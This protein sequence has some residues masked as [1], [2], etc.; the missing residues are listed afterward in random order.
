MNKPIMLL[1]GL[2]SV[3]AQADTFSNISPFVGAKGGWQFADDNSYQ[4]TNPSNYLL[5]FYGGL[6]FTP[7][8]SW[9]IG[10][11]Y[12]GKLKADASKVSIKTALIES[13]LRYD[14]YF[15]DD[16]SVY[17]RLGVVYWD[18]N[19]TQNL[20]LEG[21]GFS[22]LGEFGVNYQLTPNM[23]FNIGYQYIN[24]IGASQIG[25]Y[26][27]YSIITGVS[28]RFGGQDNSVVTPIEPL[29][30]IEPEEVLVVPVIPVTYVEVMDSELLTSIEFGFDKTLMP[31]E[32]TYQLLDTLSLLKT[33]PKARIEVIG[34]S[35]PRGPSLYN[36]L[37]STNRAEQVA[38]ILE[39]NGI[40]ASR[41]DVRGEG[42]VKLPANA[43]SEEY[44]KS[45]RV[46]IQLLSFEYKVTK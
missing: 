6:Q 9:D 42:E 25:E 2:L 1:F 10:Y 23:F 15:T 41:M 26:N 45:R 46:D 39:K 31:Q 7:T 3:T 30:I 19:K 12:Q 43:S 20:T 13:A 40:D 27:S 21:N 11:Q 5:G 24:K 36:R 18:M 29:I 28:Y 37:L 17:G 32:V 22:P 33:Y 4:Q 8:L 16:M 44:V 38:Y 35:D 34:Y 14:W